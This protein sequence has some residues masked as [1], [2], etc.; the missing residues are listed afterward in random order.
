MDTTDWKQL[1]ITVDLYDIYI[2]DL[3]NVCIK[4]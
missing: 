1:K 2:F 4:I 3:K